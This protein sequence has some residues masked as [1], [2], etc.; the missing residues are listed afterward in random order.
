VLNERRTIPP[1]SPHR[2]ECGDLQD[3]LAGGTKHCLPTALESTARLYPLENI[4]FCRSFFLDLTVAVDAGDT[5][6]AFRVPQRHE[7]SVRLLPSHFE[8]V[9]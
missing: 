9:K 7:G 8:K 3:F 4:A 1:A 5:L 2:Q 6:R